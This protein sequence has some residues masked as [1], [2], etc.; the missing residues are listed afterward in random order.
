[1]TAEAADGPDNE[2]PVA[3]EVLVVLGSAALPRTIDAAANEQDV[4]IFGADIN[5]TL[6]FSL[7]VGDVTGDG[8]ADL[9][10]GAR[11]DAGEGNARSGAGAVYILAGAPELP[12]VI[13]LAADPLPA[14]SGAQDGDTLS[15]ATV[16]AAGDKTY[17]V[18]GA[19]IARTGGLTSAG[20]VYVLDAA[21]VAGLDAPRSVAQ[22]PVRVL[23]EAAAA[24]D[25]LGRG[26]AIA[27]VTGDGLPELLVLSSL[28][29]A[30]AEDAGRVYILP[31][32]LP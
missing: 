15:H 12:A 28:A 26:S 25:S 24:G 5:D 30:Q 18:L 29:D 1:M 7:E 13:D 16:A 3:A 11:G 27:D 32:S 22:L 4:I 19:P 6:G 21:T 9:L 2:R 10:M 17:V 14:I 20:L 8:L 23:V 31:L